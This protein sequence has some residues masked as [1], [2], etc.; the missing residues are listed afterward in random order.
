MTQPTSQTTPAEAFELAR[1]RA[2]VAA[3]IEALDD[4]LHDD[5]VFGHTNGL[6]DDKTAYLAKFRSGA[7]RYFDADHRVDTAKVFGATALVKSRL[8]MK[9]ELATGVLQLNVIALTVWVLDRDHWRMV[10][11][12][13]T[14]VSA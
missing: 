6:S 13:P 7:V 12:Q 1:V 4:L 2:M 9:V 10:A 8:T 11:H 5:L 3:D 14:I